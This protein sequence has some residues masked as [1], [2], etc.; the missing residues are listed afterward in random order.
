MTKVLLLALP[1]LLSACAG[2]MITSYE[3]PTS[4]PI[5]RLGSSGSHAGHTY[6]RGEGDCNKRHIPADSLVTLIPAGKPI[7]VERV[8]NATDPDTPAY[9][10]VAVRF[11]PLRGEEYDARMVLHDEKCTLTLLVGPQGRARPLH[12]VVQVPSDCE[13]PAAPD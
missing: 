1:L 2:G 13:A 6:L 11:V 12:E 3:P 9:C 8:F 7:I 4:G 10:S 5:A